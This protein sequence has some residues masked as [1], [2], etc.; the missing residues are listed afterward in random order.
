M[1]KRIF[2]SLLAV[3]MLMGMLTTVS[4]AADEDNTYT[5]GKGQTYATLAD[6]FKA[7]AD[8]AAA[9]ITYEIYGKAEISTKGWNDIFPNNATTINL[10][11]KDDDAE[12]SLTYNGLCI[13]ADQNHKN[14]LTINYSN[15]TLSRVNG[16]W[17]GDV[18]HGNNYFTTWIRGNSE[19]VVNYTNCVF[20]NG[21]CNNQYGY[22]NYTD[23]EFSN[24]TEYCLWIYGSEVE[25]TDSSFTGAKGIKTYSENAS[26][27]IDVT[28]SDCTFDKITSK[29]AVVATQPGTITITNSTVTDCTYGFIANELRTPNSE[30]SEI[31]VD[32]KTPEYTAIFNGNLYTDT[33]YAEAEAKKNGEELSAPAAYV[34]GIPYASLQDALNTAAASSGNITVEILNDID[35]T[36]VDWNP[37]TVSGPGYPFV[38]VNG[39]NKTITNLNDMLFAGT[40]AGNSGLVINDLTIAD[41]TIEHDVNDESGNI[42]V[43]AFV[44]SPS[45]SETVTL[46]NCHLVNS[47]V[48]GGHWTG[49]LIG[50]ACGYS[51]KDGPVF[52]TVTVKDCSVTGSTIT[53]QGSVGGIVGHATADAWTEF[54]IE[55]TTVS[56]N[57]ITSTGDADNKAGVVMG[58]VGVAGQ[59]TTANGITHTGGVSVD[60]TESG[61]TVTSN[62]TAITTVYGRQGNDNGV[63]TITGGSYENAPIAESD[64]SWAAPTEGYVIVQNAEGKY[65]LGVPSPVVIF[66]SQGGSKVAEQ[67]LNCGETADKPEAPVKEGYRFGG[68]YTDLS[69]KTEYDFSTPVINDITLYAKWN[70]ITLSDVLA[71]D[72]ASW[73]GSLKMLHNQK[74]DITASAGEGGTVTPEGTTIVNYG[75]QQTYT[76]TPDEGYIIHS[77]IVD[78]VKVGKDSEYTFTNISSDHTIEIVFAAV[79]SDHHEG[80]Q[81]V[82]KNDV[83]NFIR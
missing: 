14:N 28:I 55:N 13:L 62:G 59:P 60:V 45:A 10:I 80:S 54:I 77:V 72:Y 47:T 31:T 41:S 64:S 32:D 22:T 11:G 51:G 26:A 29:P 23:C 75:G 61:N 82:S 57:T 24:E 50:W 39:N 81:A 49:G 78:G 37:V 3:L 53:G 48:S 73:L 6:A 42:G 30:L 74:Y 83:K 21:S 16:S 20:P 43:G 71:F 4:F 44:G 79:K 2:L 38:T 27:E 40:W 25:I 18:G 63:L 7:A 52:T 12:I 34:D 33:S 35:L 8:T 69:F 67:V 17:V 68:W 65:V 46:N 1:T 56:D 5:V 58:T 76:I 9:E 70:T 19:S 36:D 66:D 15:L